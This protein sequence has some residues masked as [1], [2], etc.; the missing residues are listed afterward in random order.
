MDKLKGTNTDINEPGPGI[1]REELSLLES[2]IF[3]GLGKD[4]ILVLS[5]SIPLNVSPGIYKDWTERAKLLGA[6][7]LLD[8]DGELLREAIK[9]GP[10]LVKPNINELEK[11]FGKKLDNINAAVEA[12]KRLVAEGIEIVVVSLGA[13]GAIF[14]TKNAAIRA[15]GI[16]VDVKSTVGAGDAMLAALTFALEQC[17]NLEKAVV[18]S[19]ASSAA[20]VTALGTQPPVLEDILLYEE[21]V[22]YYCLE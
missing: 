10:Y 17:Y 6:R 16:A 14:V 8:A 9:A 1:N 11:L 4:S 19:V 22:R 13:R 21:K 18:L 3:S 2:K 12:A 5:G 20:A 7:V 15:E